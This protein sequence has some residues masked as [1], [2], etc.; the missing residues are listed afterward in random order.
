MNKLDPLRLNCPSASEIPDAS[1]CLEQVTRERHV[2]LEFPVQPD[3]AKLVAESRALA[4]EIAAG[5]PEDFSVFYAGGR[6]DSDWITVTRVLPRAVILAHEQEI[7]EAARLFRRTARELVV[8]L[9]GVLGVELSRFWTELLR[10][11]V[12]EQGDAGD[13]WTYWFHGLECCFENPRTG[14]H[15]E[16][17]LCCEDEFGVLDPYFFA[18]FIRSTP[19]LEELSHLLVDGYQDV[20]RMLDVLEERGRLQRLERGLYQGAGLI[21]PD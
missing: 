19:G 17:K 20:A 2:V 18:Q 1:F 4:R 16:V 7:V 8:Q 9:A 10:V 5:L 21:A 3:G 15:L 13:G 14:Q 6:K 11:A 12:P